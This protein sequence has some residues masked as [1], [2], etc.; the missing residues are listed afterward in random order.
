MVFGMKKK[1]N[2]V[3]IPFIL[4]VKYHGIWYENEKELCPNTLFYKI[5]IPE[6][7]LLNIYILGKFNCRRKAVYFCKEK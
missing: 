3:Q 7:A 2:C 6:Y 4:K 5:S 1:M